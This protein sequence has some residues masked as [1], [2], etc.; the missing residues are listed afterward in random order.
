MVV[1]GITSL[2]RAALWSFESADAMLSSSDLEVKTH[3]DAA[4][5]MRAITQSRPVSFRI[6]RMTPRI[7]MRVV[8]MTL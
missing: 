7:P 2:Q 5:M 1:K 4:R 8:C 3:S 6:A